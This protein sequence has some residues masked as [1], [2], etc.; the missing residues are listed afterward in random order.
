MKYLQFPAIILIFGLLSCKHDKGH[1]V[2][3]TKANVSV[4]L[5]SQDTSADKKAIQSLI[6]KMLNWS[7]SKNNIDLVPVLTDST[8]SLCI[9]FDLKKLQ[10]DADKLK[11]TGFFSSEFIDN[12][13]RIVL[14]LDSEMKN[15]DFDKWSTGEL[16]PF[17]FANDVDPWCDCQDTPYDNPNPW[18]LVIVN[19]IS[20]NNTDGKLYWTFADPKSNGAADWKNPYKFD[21]KK[22]GDDWKI[23]Y[24]QGFDFKRSISY[25]K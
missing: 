7:Q 23:S 8:D 2:P 25:V 5:K 3:V 9:G 17:N 20:L 11:A 13:K 24:L 15:K 16:P 4:K 21:V 19:L 12:Y 18:D 22:E 10:E 1:E 6:R 14:T